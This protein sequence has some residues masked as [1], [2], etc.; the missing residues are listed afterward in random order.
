M[1][2]NFDYCLNNSIILIFG[3]SF[4]ILSIYHFLLYSQIIRKNKKKKEVIETSNVVP[5][6][7]VIIP[8]KDASKKL[9]SN[10]PFILNQD[11]PDFEVIVV[12]DNSEEETNDTL[13]LLEK[14]YDNLHHTFIPNTTRYV[15]TKKLALSLGI[16]ASKNEWLVFTEVDCRPASDQWLKS[17]SSNFSPSTDII[18]GYSNY[19]KAKGYFSKYITYDQLIFS[20]R[21][22]GSALLG[23]P[24]TGQGQN[25]CYRKSLF[26]KAKGFSSNLKLQR[27]E[28]DLFINCTATRANTRIEISAESVIRKEVPEFHQTWKEDKISYFV[29]SQ[30]YHGIARFVMGFESLIKYIFFISYIFILALSSYNNNWF[31]IGGS[32]LVTILY[33]INTFIIINKTTSILNDRH[34]YFTLPFFS[35]IR[36]LKN[37]RFKLHKAFMKKDDFMR[38]IIQNA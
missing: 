10:L 35:L 7:S 15:S 34:F 27:G 23:F 20:M 16:K 33:W 8:S 11:Y 2:I 37:L 1:Q 9:N 26:A 38:K 14:Q 13:M 32:T 25:L 3:I 29:T 17:L 19:E 22:L 30:L 6:I 21:Y 4:I 28:D 5:P 12:N 31:I 36:P 24:Y 18:L